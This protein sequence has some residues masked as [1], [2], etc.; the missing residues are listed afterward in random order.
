M[1]T[2]LRLTMKEYDDLT[3]AGAF[4]KLRH[5]RIELIYGELREMP[6]I[7]PPHSIATSK[8]TRWSTNNTDEDVVDVRIQQPVGVPQLDSEPEP[9]VAWAAQLNTDK[10]HPLPHEIFLLIEVANTSL[11]EDLGEMAKLYSAAGIAD[12]WVVDVRN[13]ILHV[14]RE[15]TPEGYLHHEQFRSGE[16]R[17]LAF[18][19]VILDLG[20]LFG[21]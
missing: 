19:N 5:R 12:Y 1:S 9:D 20:Y 10:R 21:D 16:V 14:F 4:D 11:A 8:L 18:P 3:E 6:R 2:A 17:P 7:N 15:P 13:K